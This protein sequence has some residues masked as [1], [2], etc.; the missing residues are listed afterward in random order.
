DPATGAVYSQVPDS[1]E[2]DLEAAVAAAE[3][4]FPAWRDMGAEKR[5]DCM[6]RLA[7]LIED[8]IEQFIRAECVDNGKPL[9][10]CR[11]IDIPRSVA[12]LHFFAEAG[13]LKN[14]QEFSS[15][16]AYS[17]TLRQ[18]YGTVATI[19]PWNLPLLLFT[20]KLAPAL[21]AG[22]CVIA[23]PSEVTPMTAY[24]LSTYANAAGIPAGALNVL[25]GR[26]PNIGAAITAHPRIPAV[27]FTGGTATGKAIYAAAASRLKRV[28][29]ELGGKNPTIIFDD[30]D[31]AKA[32]TGAKMAGFTNQGQ[33]CLCGSRILVQES[34][35]EQFRDAFVEQVKHI[36]VGDP[37]AEETLLGALVSKPHMEKVLGY[38][39]LAEQ[40]GGK[41]LSGGH[42]K[43]VPGRC[44][45]GYFVEPTVIEGLDPACR[46]MQE[47]IFGPVVSLTP[48]KDEEEAIAIA[49]GTDYGLAA[50]IWTEDAERAARV[51]ARIDS[52]IVWTNCWNLR[53]LRTPFGGMKQSG[54]GR[55]GGLRAIEFFTEEKTVTR[56]AA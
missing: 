34:V 53:D 13:K 28:S 1:G 45:E 15:D 5:A 54:V 43:I 3:Q 47:E 9:S 12:N 44:A 7:Q 51:A 24:L 30:A 14:T 50:S 21:A 40:E 32:I 17:Y 25:H 52:G 55:E 16:N 4:S 31:M 8:N 49:N 42:R 18:P 26:G 27:S 6:H 48:F 10:L 33:I 56:P 37:L 29:L 23:K 35:Y 22:N 46:T 41:I 39:D 19:S 2:K 20:W 36:V 38:I 11:V